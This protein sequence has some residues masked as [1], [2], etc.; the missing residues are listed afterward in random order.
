VQGTPQ[1]HDDYHLLFLFD[2]EFDSLCT[3]KAT[4][5]T[6]PTSKASG[7]P[8]AQTDVRSRIPISNGSWSEYEFLQATPKILT[9]VH[10]IYANGSRDESSAISTRLG[11]LAIGAGLCAGA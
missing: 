8:K 9:Q 5:Q 11:A 1:I 7:F 4:H 3:E 10:A 2:R 6:I